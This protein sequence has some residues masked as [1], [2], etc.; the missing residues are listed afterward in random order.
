MVSLISVHKKKDWL[1][2]HPKPIKRCYSLTSCTDPSTCFLLQIQAPSSLAG[3]LL[4]V[5][6]SRAVTP[7][8]MRVLIACLPACLPACLYS[9]VYRSPVCV[10]PTDHLRMKERRG[11]QEQ[12]QQQ[13]KGGRK[14]KLQQQQQ[15]QQQQKP[16]QQEEA[17]GVGDVQGL[18]PLGKGVDAGANDFAATNANTSVEAAAHKIEEVMRGMDVDQVANQLS[19]M[20]K[21]VASSLL[22]WPPKGATAA[23]IANFK[24]SLAPLLLAGRYVRLCMCRWGWGWGRVCG[25]ECGCGWVRG[26][27]RMHVFYVDL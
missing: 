23:S 25:Y 12:Q 19:G 21:H 2:F 1:N 16:Q 24:L 15:Q 27:V 7:F 13:G 18:C 10:P 14:E 20:P 11:K 6:S 17:D 22:M 3:Y 4:L 9:I 26:L 8:T 5:M